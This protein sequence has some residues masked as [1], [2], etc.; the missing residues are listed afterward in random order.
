MGLLLRAK[1][2]NY[3]MRTSKYHNTREFHCLSPGSLS[4]DLAQLFSLRM[5]GVVKREL[6]FVC[7]FMLPGKG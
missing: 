5:V 1:I 7:R 2:F 3:S 4:A 6:L